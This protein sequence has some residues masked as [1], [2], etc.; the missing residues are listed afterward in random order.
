ME[1]TNEKLHVLSCLMGLRHLFDRANDAPEQLLHDVQS[2]SVGDTCVY[3]CDVI[4]LRSILENESIGTRNGSICL[5]SDD[6]A[7]KHLRLYPVFVVLEN[8]GWPDA[9]LSW[10]S[11]IIHRNVDVPFSGKIKR[12]QINEPVPGVVKQSILDIIKDVDASPEVIVSNS[13]PGLSAPNP[14][15]AGKQRFFNVNIQRLDINDKIIATDA[16]AAV[17]RALAMK[18]KSQNLPGKPPLEYDVEYWIG[19]EFWDQVV[20]AADGVFNMKKAQKKNLQTIS[21]TNQERRIFQFIIN[22]KKEF[23]LPTEFRVAGGWIRDRLMGQESDDIDIAL[24][25]MTGQTFVDYATKSPFA[26]EALGKSYTVEANPEQSKHL[27]TASIEIYGQK[28]DFVNLRSEE[29]ADTRIPTAKMGTPESD[30]SRRDL[31][32]NSLFYNVETGQIEDYVGGLEDL[33][34]GILKTP[35]DPLQTF[36][37]DPLRVLRTLRFYSRFPGFEIDHATKVAMADSRVHEAYRNKVSPERA[38]PEIMKMMQ[39]AQPHKAVEEMFDTEFYRAVFDSSVLED[40]HPDGIKMDQRT[41]FHKHNLMM[42]TVEVMRNLNQIMI[43]N[44]ENSYMRGLMNMAGLLHDVGKMKTSI[45][46]LYRDQ[47]VRPGEYTYHGHEIE[48][49]KMGEDLM[50]QWGIPDDARKL[51]NKVVSMHMRVHGGEW[52]NKAMGKFLRQ[53]QIPGQEEKLPDLWKYVFYHGMADTLAS[54]PEVAGP[55]VKRLQDNIGRFEEFIQNQGAGAVNMHKPL[56]DGNEIIRLVPEV[57]P[58]TGFIKEV[59]DLLLES[60]YAGEVKTPEQARERVLAMKPDILRKY[61]NNEVNAMNWWSKIK[62][63][64]QLPTYDS[65]R[66]PISEDENG[67]V[68]MDRSVNFEFKPKDK[69]RD[70]QK[71]LTTRQSF[72]NVKSIEDGV[73]TIEWEDKDR[74]DEQ[75]LVTDT[76]ALHTRLARA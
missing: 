13:V 52:S 37:D 58:K 4:E 73:I 33:Q 29:Y 49:E 68:H 71:S 32:I 55:G 64:Y 34:S 11:V 61:L 39:G 12:L 5:F 42:H 59:V 47:S 14:R 44:G 15:L 45:Q 36:I 56:I 10:G 31:T 41:K 16:I 20:K 25:G 22:V 40:I 2:A 54:K 6:F 21:L 51:I 9:C 24:S 50:K 69:V 38:G 28:I 75:F 72:G 27:E 18:W 62:R 76:I 60:Q 46:Q 74:E 35:L 1:T 30:A 8:K 23:N 43:D 57:Q 26:E 53:T 70:R 17:Q 3:P 19:S 66:Q 65:P 7:N 48:S 67:V 63:A